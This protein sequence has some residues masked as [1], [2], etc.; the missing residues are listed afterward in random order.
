MSKHNEV[1]YG[2]YN[3]EEILLEAIR[4]ANKKGLEIMEV[5]TPF[6]PLVS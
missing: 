2:L 5:Y 6:P 3:D 1:L 4:N